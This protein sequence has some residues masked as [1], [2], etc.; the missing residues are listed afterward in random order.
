MSERTFWN[1]VRTSLPIEKMYRVENKVAEGMPDVHYLSN[2]SSGWIELKYVEDWPQNKL[3]IGLRL[4]QAFW[5]NEYAANNGR[6]WILLRVGKEFIGLING[7]SANQLVDKVDVPEFLDC[8]V[9]KKFGMMTASD[10]QELAN[11]ITASS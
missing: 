6:C 1:Y 5:L 2:G 7:S 11:V 4:K 9:Y 3:S 8:L 10:W